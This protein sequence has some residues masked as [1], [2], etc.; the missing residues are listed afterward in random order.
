MGE[1]KGA[2]R[3]LGQ[4]LKDSKSNY[5]KVEQQLF[6]QRKLFLELEKQLKAL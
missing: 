6:E 3:D 2:V 1:M 5:D 4:E